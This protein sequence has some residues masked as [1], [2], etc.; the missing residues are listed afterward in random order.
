MKFFANPKILADA[1]TA[2]SKVLPSKPV[3]PALENILVT[4]TADGD[5]HL[6]G[7]DKESALLVVLPTDNELHVETPGSILVGAKLILNILKETDGTVFFDTDDPNVDDNAVI[8]KWSN[9]MASM[10]VFNVADYPSFKD[11]P[12]NEALTTVSIPTEKLLDGINAVL[13]AVSENNDLRPVLNGVHFDISQNGTTLVGTDSRLMMFHTIA[14]AA[15]PSEVSFNLPR[16]NAVLV[17]NA[18]AAA[19]KGDVKITF[20]DQRATFFFTETRTRLSSLLLVGKY[21]KWRQVVPKA[22]G[23]ELVVDR[24]SFLSSLRRIILSANELTKHLVLRFQ[25]NVINLSARN[26]A[27]GLAAQENVNSTLT[28]CD[29]IT[30]S[31]KGD[32]LISAVSAMNS[33]VIRVVFSDETHA[34]LIEPSE[35]E[36]DDIHT[37]GVL[38]PVKPS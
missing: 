14:D 13:A 36:K 26:M 16:R 28:G 24:E 32:H 27:Y 33:V 22:T 1:V 11:F 21:P 23:K 4:A 31:F 15:L 38:M 30:I 35:A 5:V 8:V 3:E 29:D 6:F 9:G 25:P 17:R 19:K 2:I 12:D 34:V 37:C 20:S 7:S 10:P 18:C